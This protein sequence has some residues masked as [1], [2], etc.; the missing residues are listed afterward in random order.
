M[1]D[2][3]INTSNSCN[4]ATENYIETLNSL[5]CKN[6]IDIP[7]RFGST[8]QSTLDHIITNHDFN[9]FISED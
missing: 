7:T 6:L 9:S 5:G 8:S 4:T 3:N 1:G 2:I